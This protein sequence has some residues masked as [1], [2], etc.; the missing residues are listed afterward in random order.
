MNLLRLGL[1][2]SLLAVWTANKSPEELPVADTATRNGRAFVACRV[3][4]TG[5]IPRKVP[6]R[7]VLEVVLRVV[8]GNLGKCRGMFCDAMG[9]EAMLPEFLFADGGYEFLQVEGF[10]VGYVLEVAGAEGC[11]GGSQH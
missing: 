4:E 6:R 9:G 8:S 10:E 2:G 11:Q 1:T 3:W 7:A 5:E